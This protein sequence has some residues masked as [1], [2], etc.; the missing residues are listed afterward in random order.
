[1]RLGHMSTTALFPGTDKPACGALCRSVSRSPRPA[2]NPSCVIRTTCRRPSA[3]AGPPPPAIRVDLTAIEV[4]GQLADGTTYSY[5][6]FDGAIPGP[7]IRVR[8]GDTLEVH[9]KN[10][11]TSVRPEEH[12]P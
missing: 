6:T 2:A 7:M 12:T 5:F 4:V 1:M 8:V 11:T 10:E 9:M 3:A